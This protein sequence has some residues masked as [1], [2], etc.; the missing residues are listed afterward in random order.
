M[1]GVQGSVESQV[2]AFRE[3]AVFLGEAAVRA[4]VSLSGPPALGAALSRKV[5]PGRGLRGCVVGL[6]RAAGGTGEA[7]G[8]CPMVMREPGTVGHLC[9]PHEGMDWLWAPAVGRS[10]CAKQIGLLLQWQSPQPGQGD[11][12]EPGGQE[13]L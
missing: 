2:K 6:P 5:R 9:R 1:A 10:P 8:C 4:P 13:N 3:E 11:R 12:Q 7:A